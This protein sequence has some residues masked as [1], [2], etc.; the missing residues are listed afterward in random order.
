MIEPY[1]GNQLK[2]RFV[3]MDS[4]FATT[5]NFEFIVKYKNEFIVALKDNRMFASSL[6]EKYQG[7][8]INKVRD[9][10]LSDN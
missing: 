2:F 8:F 1:L 10:A 7:R 9:V 4:W 6:E 5:E 3:L